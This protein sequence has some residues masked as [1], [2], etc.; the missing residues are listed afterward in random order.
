MLWKAA[1]IICIIFSGL[2]FAETNGTLNF[3]TSNLSITSGLFGHTVQLCNSDTNCFQYK[4]F[5]DYDGQSESSYAGWCNQTS[6]TSCY[7]NVSSTVAASIPVT[8]GTS[9]CVSSTA[10][11]TCTSGTWGSA[12]SCGSNQTCSS[13]ACSASSSSSSSSSGSSS[14]TTTTTN[15]TKTPKITILSL[16]AS[17]DIVQGNSVTKDIIINNSGDLNLA[18]ISVLITGINDWASLTPAI[19]PSLA[20]GTRYTF[21]ITINI[22]KNADVETYTANVNVATNY[23]DVSASG[24]FSFNVLPS[25]KTIETEIT[26]RYYTYVALLQEYKNLTLQ[27]GGA[28]ADELNS[29]LENAQAKLDKAKVALDAG[30]YF[31]AKQLLDDAEGLLN[32]TKITLDKT[33]KPLDL[34]LILIVGIA[35][36]AVALLAYMLVPAKEPGKYNFKN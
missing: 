24:S 2:A 8:T 15:A 14:G 16:P 12:V 27:K 36:A 20:K 10:Y 28:N 1:V 31:D 30:S 11:R 23:T 19:L 6:I 5:L 32:A 4:C 3:S 7:K 18:N 9:F 13:G 17:F 22:P 33:E 26:P 35:V 21:S 29:L 25:N 34:V